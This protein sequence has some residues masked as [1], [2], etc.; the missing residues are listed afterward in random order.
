[1]TT[2]YIDKK[3]TWKS[4]K[5]KKRQLS[6]KRKIAQARRDTLH[7]RLGGV[8]ADCGIEAGKTLM[9]IHHICYQFGYDKNWG[10]RWRC[11]SDDEF[12]GSYVPEIMDCCILLCRSC[13]KKRHGR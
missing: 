8:C 5:R 4:P 2:I 6:P 12:W 7:K 11:V 3:G 10:K 13:H 9:N 1:M